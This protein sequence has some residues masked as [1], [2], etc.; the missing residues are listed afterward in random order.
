MKTNKN[1]L[2]AG[3]LRIVLAFL[4]VM[5]AA[6]VLV[7][8]LAGRESG[9]RNGGSLA[10]ASPSEPWTEAQTVKPADLVKELAEAKGSNRPVVV[11]AGFRFLYESAHVPGAVFHG[12]ASKPEGLDD[13]KKWAQGIPHSS[14]V[15]VYCGC[16]P[17]EQ[18]PNIRPAFETLRSMGF[19]HLRV[20]VLPNN[21][22]KDWVGQGYAAEKGR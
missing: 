3:A 19:Q 15:V 6:T 20:L 16:C 9:E 22:A 12:P 1:L 21:F 5:F 10:T 17:F 18:C 14:N 2:M 13:L 8:E 7:H 11:C 4:I